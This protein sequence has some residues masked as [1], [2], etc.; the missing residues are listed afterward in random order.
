M[1]AI[2]SVFS[3]FIFSSPSHTCSCPVSYLTLPPPH[4]R[5]FSLSPLTPPPSIPLSP[6]YNSTSHV[7]S[8]PVSLCSGAA[9]PVGSSRAP[10]A[11]HRAWSGAQR[12]L[13]GSPVCG[14]P[15]APWREGTDIPTHTCSQTLAIWREEGGIMG[16]KA[17]GEEKHADGLVYF[18]L[19]FFCVWEGKH[20]VWC[21]IVYF[22]FRNIYPTLYIYIPCLYTIIE[23]L[24]LS[25]LSRF[26][27]YR[28]VLFFP[29]I[30]AVWF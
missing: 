24:H 30:T 10:A 2:S 21:T 29:P 15:P 16:R 14:H 20:C 13:P 7:L 12:Q 19:L 11:L 6:S 28:V 9:Q 1:A 25:I 18:Y 26:L 17:P 23:C 5:L 4:T 22:L 8:L 3:S 27:N